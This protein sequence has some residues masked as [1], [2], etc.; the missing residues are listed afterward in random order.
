M[1]T[2]NSR[3]KGRKE[4]VGGREEGESHPRS[5]LHS[6]SLS[7]LTDL[8]PSLS[9]TPHVLSTEQFICIIPSVGYGACF[10]K[11]QHY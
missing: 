6:P 7:F 4:E 11:E 9:P 5:T 2:N 1:V 10:D 8:F 3:D